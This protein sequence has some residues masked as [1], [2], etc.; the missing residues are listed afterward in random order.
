MVRHLLRATTV[1]AVAALLA[2]PAFGA[3][4][5]KTGP[6]Y[7][8]A[9]A[10]HGRSFFEATCAVCHGVH[11]EGGVGPALAGSPLRLQHRYVGAL[12]AF[13]TVN[14]PLSAPA[15]L[16]RNEYVTIMAY[17]LSKNGHAAGKTPLTFEAAKKSTGRM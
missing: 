5:P 10:L 4:A 15:S 3:D 11:L 14:M 9:Q 13:M 17:L 1:L 16:S 12:F 8:P 2:T 6:S 7:L